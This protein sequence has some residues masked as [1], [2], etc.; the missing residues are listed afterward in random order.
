MQEEHRRRQEEAA[1]CSKNGL[2]RSSPTQPP[3]APEARPDCSGLLLSGT[4]EERLG[5]LDAEESC[6]DAPGSAQAPAQGL[7]R[8]AELTTLEP[9]GGASAGR[10]L[11]AHVRHVG[12]GMGIAMAMA[13]GM[14]MTMVMVP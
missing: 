7:P 14:T 1:A 3:T 8:V 13:M 9:A 2:A 10:G 6:G 5:R 12:V 11:C 4:R